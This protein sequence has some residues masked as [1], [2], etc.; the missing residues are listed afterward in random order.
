MATPIQGKYLSLTS[1]RRDGTEVATPVWFVPD[2]GRLLVVTDAELGQGEADPAQPR[3]QDGSLLRERPTA[4][5]PGP[6]TRRGAP[7]Q[8]A[9]PRRQALLASKYRIDTAIVKPIRA[10][11]S[12]L[13]IG[14]RRS[15]AVVLA[16]T[17]E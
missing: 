7:G 13:H 12:A 8:R 1:F 5:R 2:N 15:K 3:N 4:R 11:Q 14:R 6:G 16:I 17:P 10:V 9:T